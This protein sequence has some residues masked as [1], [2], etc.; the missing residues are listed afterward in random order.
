M[1]DSTLEAFIDHGTLARRFD[2]DVDRAHRIWAALGDAGIDMVDVAHQLEREG[3]EK[4]TSAFDELVA[5]L[6]Q[7][8]HELES[9]KASTSP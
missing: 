8:R 9:A 7:K 5:T 2:D 6:A 3:V 4:F 1:T